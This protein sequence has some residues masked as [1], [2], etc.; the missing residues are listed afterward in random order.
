MDFLK[1]IGSGVILIVV[2]YCDLVAAAAGH[3]RKRFTA[4]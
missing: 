3:L 1:A 2:V 4:K